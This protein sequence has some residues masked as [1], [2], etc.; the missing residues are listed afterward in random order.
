MKK[1]SKLSLL[2][3]LVFVLAACNPDFIVQKTDEPANQIEQENKDDDTIKDDDQDVVTDDDLDSDQGLEDM[4]IFINIK[5]ATGAFYDNFGSTDIKIKKIK[6]GQDDKCLVYLI[7]GF[8]DQNEYKTVLN[9]ENGQILAEETKANEIDDDDFAIEVDL[10]ITPDQAMRAA[11]VKSDGSFVEEW[12]LE[13]ED[14]G[15]YYEVDLQGDIEVKV[16]A[17]TGEVVKVDK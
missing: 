3:G 6:L 10:L 15:I 16:N 11:L 8:D 2:L 1:F 12:T 9:A 13:T 14:G 17:E 4:E 5:E 7:E